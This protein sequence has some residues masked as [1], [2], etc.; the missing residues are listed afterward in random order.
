[1]VLQD[2]LVLPVSL[3]DLD[4]QDLWVSLVHLE[5]KELLDP[6]EQMELQVLLGSLDLQVP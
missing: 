3:G 5:H 1:M 2:P 4:L 6:M